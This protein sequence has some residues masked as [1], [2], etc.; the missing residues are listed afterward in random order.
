M[1][2][3]YAL[4]GSGGL[5]GNDAQG[6]FI[7]AGA[8]EEGSISGYM[9]A[10]V[11]RVP[12]AQYVDPVAYGSNMVAQGDEAA[13]IIAGAGD[14]KGIWSQNQFANFNGLDGQGAFAGAVGIG[15][16]SL[17][18]VDYIQAKTDGHESSAFE[19]D[20]KAKGDEAAIVAAG[21]GNF[22]LNAGT[23]FGPS[24]LYSYSM[25]DMQGAIAGA[26]AIGSDSRAKASWVGAITDGEMT[27]AA[28]D[29]LKA[30]SNGF[31]G[32]GAG[33]GSLYLAHGL[34]GSPFFFASHD[35]LGAQGAI[36]GAA[37]LGEN[38]KVKADHIGAETDGDYTYA[39]GSDLR[40]KS[41]GFA[42]L[43][44]G[45]GSLYLDHGLID[46]PFFSATNDNVGVQGALAGAVAGGDDSMAS[47]DFVGALT[48]GETTFA[49]GYRMQASGDDFA[50]LVAGAGSL[51]MSQGIMQSPFFSGS[52]DSLSVQG[53]IA[54]AAAGGEDSRASADFVGALTDG[55]ITL[56]GGHRIQ[57]GGDDFA[58]I[59][60]GAGRLYM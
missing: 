52:L 36:A 15:E 7:A 54:G 43:I 23:V 22:D 17:A 11:I 12:D 46:S 14:L 9:G 45:A 48:D 41:D 53:A 5:N 44:A 55:E 38:S 39:W 34:M 30:K 19:V 28:G 47:A 6:S 25:F 8:C 4:V 24:L 40:A 13:G 10:E 18:S 58:G 3:G 42:G 57:A 33:A 20:A 51:Y 29:H 27:S 21:A 31:A 56:A 59:V 60:A 35:G 37:A 50:G 1:A 26:T 16:N 2:V 49:E 32:V